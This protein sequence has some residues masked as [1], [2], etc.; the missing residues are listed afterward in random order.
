[1]ATAQV[2]GIKMVLTTTELQDK[3]A[4]IGRLDI[5]QPTRALNFFFCEMEE[6][7]FSPDQPQR[8]IA[9]SLLLRSRPNNSKT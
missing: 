5:I 6:V 1:M 2:S 3:L 7:G 8:F 4:I 9:K